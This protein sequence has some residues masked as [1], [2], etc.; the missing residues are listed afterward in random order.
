MQRFFQLALDLQ[1]SMV[2]RKVDAW[3]RHQGCQLFLVFY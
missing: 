3:R 1:W 2:A